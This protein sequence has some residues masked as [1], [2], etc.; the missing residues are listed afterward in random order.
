MGK[1]YLVVGASRGIGAEV[2]KHFVATGHRVIGVSRTPAIAGEWLKA[3]VSTPEGIEKIIQSVTSETIDALLYMGGTWEAGAF[4]DAFEITRSP[5]AE[6]RRVID[7]NTIAPIEI[8][9]G[10]METLQRSSNPKAIFIGALSGFDN[11]ATKEVA[12]TA[13]KFGLRGAVQSLRVAYRGYGVGFSVINPGNVATAEVLD[14][15]QSGRFAAQ[16][17]IPMADLI[18]T[19]EWILQLSRDVDV[20]EVNLRQR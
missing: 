19:I 15:I 20:S 16:T 8:T 13:S 14:D 10:L 17:P 5:Y 18:Q 1:T 2:A 12:N 6:T 3:D 4:T 9:K 7:V 11:G